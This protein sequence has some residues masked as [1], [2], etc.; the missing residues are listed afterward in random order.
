[1]DNAK[2][3][4]TLKLKDSSNVL[5]TVSKN[6]SVDQLAA[7][8][9]LSLILNKLNK[10]CAG[11]FSGQI[12]STI[13]FLKPE[14]TIEKS[15][16]S[17]RD[18][19]I[20]LDKNKADKLRYKVEDNIVRIFI[21][22]YKTSITEKDLDFSQGD[23][24]VDILV[25]LGV[26]DQADLDEAIT[27]HGRILHDALVTSINI[28]PK[29]GLGSINWQ[30][31]SASSLSELIAELA[32]NLGDKIFDEQ[33][34]TALLT[35]IVSETDR[36]SNHKTTP[37]T[38]NISSLLMSAGANQQLIATKLNG[39]VD[40]KGDNA[41]TSSEAKTTD[42]NGTL[43][44]SHNLPSELP[45]PKDEE[46][47][48][49]PA[50]LKPGPKLIT[51]PPILGG[52][53]TGSSTD[54]ELEASTDPLSAPKLPKSDDTLTHTDVQP[55]DNLTENIKHDEENTVANIPEEVKMPV[56][57]TKE[58]LDKL[59]LDDL[60]KKVEAES[61]QLTSQATNNNNVTTEE[62]SQ[63]KPDNI[64]EVNID[65]NGTITQ[66]EKSVGSHHPV[67]E[68]QQQDKIE[69]ARKN[70]MYALNDQP[71]NEAPKP[72]ESIGSQP[73]GEDLHV[74]DQP[75]APE[76]PPPMVEPPYTNQ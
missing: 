16:D 46:E 43:Q 55:I 69:E 59:T 76:V 30:E 13:E 24:N 48:S 20:A 65:S 63:D 11:V 57:P 19:I 18:F 3:Q 52:T 38:M 5:V 39:Q 31:P 44:I 17:L 14:K 7:L 51:Q 41:S 12:P 72:L 60:S 8:I 68:E 36:F 34:A 35:G 40:L 71:S 50:G 6:P 61:P 73:L 42:P 2:Q 22:P 66:L 15:T 74:N 32:Q 56:P 54:N 21:T 23:F 62:I 58:D 70:T 10:H 47:I 9:G 49:T 28:S 67:E 53:L 29:G 25:A 4:L 33:I 27:A 64:P 45:E 1:M 26:T 75:K 37:Q